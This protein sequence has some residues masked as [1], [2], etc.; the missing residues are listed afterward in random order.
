MRFG[1]GQLKANKHKLNK[2]WVRGRWRSAH[3][4]AGS[5]TGAEGLISITQPR[6]LFNDSCFVGNGA[7]GPVAPEIAAGFE[8]SYRCVKRNAAS[9]LAGFS[10]EN[11]KLCP[12]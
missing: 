10:H 12:S 11:S 7:G 3:D 6:T 1:A 9:H 5:G 2:S 4:P 8:K